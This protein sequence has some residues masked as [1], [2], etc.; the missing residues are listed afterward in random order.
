MNTLRLFRRDFALLEHSADGSRGLVH[1]RTLMVKLWQRRRRPLPR[2]YRNM[3]RESY[4]TWLRIKLISVYR[5]LIAT[6][7]T[8]PTRD[9]GGPIPSPWSLAQRPGRTTQGSRHPIL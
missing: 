6:F 2:C 4:L 1:D 5:P 8:P 9:S 7:V 3:A